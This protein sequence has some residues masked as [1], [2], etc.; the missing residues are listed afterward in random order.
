MPTKG[1]TTLGV[2]VGN[3]GFFPA[4][5]CSTGRTEILATLER[6]GYRAVALDTETT[7]HGAVES[8]SDARACADF[9]TDRCGSKSFRDLADQG[10]SAFQKDH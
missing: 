4:M 6:E 5:L 1:P 7:L 9:R 3:R 10:L 2:I 8:L